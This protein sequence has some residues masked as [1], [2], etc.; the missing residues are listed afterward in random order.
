MEN[1]WWSPDP[2]ELQIEEGEKGY[3]LELLMGGS[4]SGGGG[5]AVETPSAASSKTRQP[6]KKGAVQKGRPATSKGKGKSNGEVPKEGD[7]SSTKTRKEEA[8]AQSGGEPK[9]G[10]QAA[11]ARRYHLTSLATRDQGTR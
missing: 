6:A 8:G 5:E 11:G 3:F 4:A 7:E 1:S 2:R 9:E 10:N